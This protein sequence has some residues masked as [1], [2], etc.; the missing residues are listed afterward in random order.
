MGKSSVWDCVQLLT[1]RERAQVAP[2]TKCEAPRQANFRLGLRDITDRP[3][4]EARF[5]EDESAYCVLFTLSP[6][7]GRAEPLKLPT[8]ESSSAS[9]IVISPSL[10]SILRMM[11][12]VAGSLMSLTFL[13]ICR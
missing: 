2:F 6:T 12:P 3:L 8:E 11:A 1:G 5:N 13:T 7:F 10:F 9:L 4:G